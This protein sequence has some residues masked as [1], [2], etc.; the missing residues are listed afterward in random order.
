MSF[1]PRIICRQILYCRKG[2]NVKT[3][4]EKTKVIIKL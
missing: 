1:L 2:W 4:S 3:V